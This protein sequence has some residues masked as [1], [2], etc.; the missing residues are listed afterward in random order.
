MR[1]TASE[2][3]ERRRLQRIGPLWATCSAIR[4]SIC[5]SATR[6][7]R[8]RRLGHDPLPPLPTAKP[9][10]LLYNAGRHRLGCPGHL[11]AAAH[12][13]VAQAVEPLAPAFQE[14]K[15]WNSSWLSRST[16]GSE[17]VCTC[18]NGGGLG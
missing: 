18:G 8:F 4:S 16:I 5:F 1:W 7:I 10:L 9:K 2:P 3:G 17:P 13:D 14:L 12:K 15:A 11:T 6:R